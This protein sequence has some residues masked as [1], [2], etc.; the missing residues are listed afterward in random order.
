M[1]KNL[2]SLGTLGSNGYCYKSM[3][4]LIK[5]SR[6]VKVVIKRQKVEDNIYKL[7]SNTIVGGVTAVTEFE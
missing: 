3:N 6:G 4:G 1:K 2:I 7:F 5:V